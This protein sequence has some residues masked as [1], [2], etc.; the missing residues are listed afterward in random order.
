MN[1]QTIYEKIIFLLNH[2]YY[3]GFLDN[4]WGY[5]EK[6]KSALNNEYKIPYS[7][8]RTYQ[9]GDL[10]SFEANLYIC[11]TVSTNVDPDNGNFRLINNENY[12]I[13][14]KLTKGYFRYSDNL[15][16]NLAEIP[17]DD[18]IIENRFVRGNINGIDK[19]R[20]YIV[21]YYTGS[22]DNAILIS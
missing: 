14:C 9:E 3:R 5:E 7:S 10:C 22:G 2:F 13:Q 4:L 12:S 8:T 18:L 1:C 11:H 15:Q 21:Y 6:V 16:V 17:E 20:I 19:S